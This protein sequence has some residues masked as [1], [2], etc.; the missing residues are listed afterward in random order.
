MKY[1]AFG[2]THII[3]LDAG[4]KIVETLM[5]L[6][7]LDKIGAGVFDDLDRRKAARSGATVLDRMPDDR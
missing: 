3:R 6:C 7:K 2:P 4:E 1:F 5:S